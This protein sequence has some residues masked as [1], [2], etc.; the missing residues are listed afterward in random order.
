MQWTIHNRTTT[1]GCTQY[2]CERLH[3]TDSR[4]ILVTV[5]VSACIIAIQLYTEADLVAGVTAVRQNGRQ[6]RM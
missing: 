5:L 1:E 3:S 4:Y 6:W 2:P